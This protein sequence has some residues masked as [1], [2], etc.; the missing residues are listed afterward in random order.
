MMYF[1][2]L[3]IM[4]EI[5]KGGKM[6]KILSLVMIAAM[7]VFFSASISQAITIEL[8]PETNQVI[9]GSNVFVDTN[10]SGL[11]DDDLGEFDIDIDY[12]SSILTFKSF[13]L[14]NTLMVNMGANSS[15]PPVNVHASTDLFYPQPDN[16]TLF[17]LNFEA[18]AAGTSPLDMTVNALLDVS[19]ASLSWDEPRNGNITVVPEPATLLLL[20]SGLAGLGFFRRR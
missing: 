3:K 8:K 18:M 10:I 9:V 6:K 20:G 17:Q 13:T 16:F 14:G 15:P 12:V 5:K 2:F 4:T 7:L 11:V 19:G 1:K